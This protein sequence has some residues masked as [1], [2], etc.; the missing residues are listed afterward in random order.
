MEFQHV[1]ALTLRHI[2]LWTKDPNLILITL[3]WPLLDILVWGFLGSWIQRGQTGSYDYQAICLFCILLWQANCRGAIYIVTGFLEEIWAFNLLNLFSLPL[4]IREWICGVLLFDLIFSLLV[5][6]Y[7]IGLIVL[8]YSIPLLTIL[9][10]FILFAPP[11]MISGAWLGFMTLHI[12]TYMGKRAQE[13]GWILAWFFSP[14]CGVFYPIDVFP[15]WVQKISYCLPM[16]YVFEGLRNYLMHDISPARNLIIAY[17][18]GITY[19]LAAI[20][21]FAWLFKRTK[22][23]GLARLSD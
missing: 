7:C 1:W 5:I 14:L 3:Y 17:M 21:I 6:F 16:T 2:R 10:V 20:G 11:L 18:M 4:T 8:F 9:K 12:I 19:A 23:Q 15:A 22:I 13:L